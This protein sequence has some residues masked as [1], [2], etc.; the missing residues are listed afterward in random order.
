MAKRGTSTSPSA[1]KSGDSPVPG[2]Y[3]DPKTRD[4][5]RYWD[6]ESWSPHTKERTLTDRGSS[7]ADQVRALLDSSAVP[8]SWSEHRKTHLLVAIGLPVALVMG[9]VGVGLW[10]LGIGVT[11]DGPTAAPA[12]TVA[13]STTAGPSE[14]AQEAADNTPLESASTTTAAPTTTVPLTDPVETGA[15][16]Y[17]VGTEI[18]PGVYRVSISWA[19]LDEEMDVI[20]ND[21]TLSGI[22]IMTVY[23]TDSFIELT[24]TAMPLDLVPTLDPIDAG[25]TQGTYL[26]GTDLQPGLYRITSEPGAT[27][28]A[29]RLASDL[30]VLE[31]FQSGDTVEIELIDGDF[32]LRYTGTLELVG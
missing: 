31:S 5:L 3:R 26:V 20:D 27:A 16:T 21:L 4:R 18:L 25:F 23:E 22:S 12:T 29:A 30:E 9:A 8:T 6:G 32:A 2:W 7:G 13:P 28:F 19:R 17:A 15:G 10:I 1:R 24:G 14:S 11:V